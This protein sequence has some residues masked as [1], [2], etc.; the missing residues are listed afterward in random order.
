MCGHYISGRV[1]G[2]NMSRFREMCGRPAADQSCGR[3]HDVRPA[4]WWCGNSNAAII[5]SGQARMPS[6]LGV[7]KTPVPNGWFA[8]RRHAD[9]VGLARAAFGRKQSELQRQSPTQRMARDPNWG[10][11]TERRRSEIIQQPRQQLLLVRPT[12]VRPVRMKPSTSTRV[13]NSTKYR[14]VPPSSTV[15]PRNATTPHPL[16][17]P[18]H[19]SSGLAAASFFM[20][21][22]DL[23]IGYSVSHV[24]GPHE[25]DRDRTSVASRHQCRRRV[26]PNPPRTRFRPIGKIVRRLPP[27]MERRRAVGAKFLYGPVGRQESG[28]NPRDSRSGSRRS[29]R[30]LRPPRPFRRPAGPPR[31]LRLGRVGPDLYG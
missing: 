1:R 8:E 26:P 31:V 23:D 12:Y 28:L 29:R 9:L 27:S 5:P 25:R 20:S 17:G 7:K 2:A 18:A 24:R 3:G 15:Q 4:P 30:A 11:S 14:I 19:A 21:F 22:H 6:P 16:K 13:F 10:I